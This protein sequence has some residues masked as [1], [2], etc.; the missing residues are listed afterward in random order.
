MKFPEHLRLAALAYRLVRSVAHLVAVV[1][2]EVPLQGC[3]LVAAHFRVV[4][5]PAPLLLREE[6]QP[7]CSSV[8]AAPRTSAYSVQCPQMD[9][10]DNGCLGPILDPRTRQDSPRDFGCSPGRT[11]SGVRLRDLLLGSCVRLEG[12]K[13]FLASNL[14]RD[15][16][17]RFPELRDWS[18]ILRHCPTGPAL[19]AV[20]PSGTRGLGSCRDTLEG[21][22]NREMCF[23]PRSDESPPV[24]DPVAN[25]AR[26]SVRTK[27]GRGF[28]GHIA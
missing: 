16:S 14:V 25:R 23:R 27:F 17:L 6:T 4:V 18:W 20:G 7:R 22:G 11:R 10:V 19:L 21:T 1:L 2:A 15:S 13:R 26:Q 5:L 9:G 28:F 12:R 8:R 3:L 24:S